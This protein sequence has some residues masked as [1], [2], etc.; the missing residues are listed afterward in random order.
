MA[1]DIAT[2]DAGLAP[3]VE[4]TAGKLRGISSAG[5]FS[6]K[7]IPYGADTT[8]APGWSTGSFGSESWASAIAAST[9]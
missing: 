6:L 3:I 5:I 9:F 7:G 1:N 2:A 4:I 8:G